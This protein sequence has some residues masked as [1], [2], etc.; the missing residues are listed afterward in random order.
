[1]KKKIYLICVLFIIVGC[2]NK[3]ICI[4][5]KINNFKLSLSLRKA[6]L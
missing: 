3:K 1:M 5:A 2:D 4:S 6:K